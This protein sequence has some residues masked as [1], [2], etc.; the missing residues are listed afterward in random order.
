MVWFVMFIS[1]HTQKWSIYLKTLE[2]L[3]FQSRNHISILLGLTTHWLTLPAPPKKT[4]FFS[5][6][7]HWK[8]KLLICILCPSFSVTRPFWF[9]VTLQ[10][11]NCQ[12]WKEGWQMQIALRIYW[13]TTALQSFVGTIAVWMHFNFSRNLIEPCF[14]VIYIFIAINCKQELIWKQFVKAMCGM[15]QIQLLKSV[16]Y[17]SYDG[18]KWKPQKQSKQ[19]KTLWK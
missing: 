13:W 19:T 18:R 3:H 12:G 8:S 16:P 15:F 17:L 7:V 1:V 5:T 6:I 4:F 11:T 10:K 2:R 14:F 9:M